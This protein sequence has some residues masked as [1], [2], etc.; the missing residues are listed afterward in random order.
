MRYAMTTVMVAVGLFAMVM[1]PGFVEASPYN[2]DG[3]WSSIPCDKR[4]ETPSTEELQAVAID[5]VSKHMYQCN[6]V[7][8][9]HPCDALEQEQ[10]AAKGQVHKKDATGSRVTMYLCKGQFQRA[11]CLD[12]ST[13]DDVEVEKTRADVE[14]TEPHVPLD[15]EDRTFTLDSAGEYRCDFNEAGAAIAIRS[16]E[17]KRAGPTVLLTGSVTNASTVATTS[18][19]YIQVLDDAKRPWVTKAALPMK[20]GATVSF[21][22]TYRGFETVPPWL[23]LSLLYSPAAVCPKVAVSISR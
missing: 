7:W 19:I 8:S 23:S 18:P 16:L 6:G 22:L 15:D 9:S 1:D 2:C 13:S 14:Q 12:A 21:A 11:P 10:A 5:P 20:P 4:V 3:V 17:A